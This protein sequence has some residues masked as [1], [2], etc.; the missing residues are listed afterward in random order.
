MSKVGN[1]LKMLMILQSRGKMK[2]KDLARE[3]EVSEREIR[4]YKDDLIQAGIY[5]ESDAG[6][7]GG[8]SIG[9]DSYLLC[10][11]FTDQEY[12]ALLMINEELKKSNHLV[13]KDYNTAIDKINI[14]HKKKMHNLSNSY[15]YMLKGAIANINFQKERKKLIDI[16]AA[17]LTKN[18]VNIKY[19][20]LT[21]GQTERVVWPYATFQYKGDM[22]FTGYC[23]RR[24]ATIYFKLCRVN[25][26]SVLEEKFEMDKP[27]DLEE[28][29]KNCFGIFKDQ[30]IQVKL[31]IHYPMSQ[32]VK[33]KIWVENQ[34]II[35]N[36][37]DKSIIFE[38]MMEGLEEIKSWILSM[39]GS[40]EVIEPKMLIEEIKKE[41]EKMKSIY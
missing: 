37:E 15:N 22:Y 24:K 38:A 3:I 30:A 32:I 8:Y 28:Y 17:I 35:E 23:E 29:M 20:S 25:K 40:V 18:K 10:L 33:E 27:F 36:E 7:Y 12:M 39:G 1:E 5:I 14:V 21:S 16:H 11:N 6:K 41:I 19:T 26:Y 4:R 9:N 34:K 13:L 31:K 2:A